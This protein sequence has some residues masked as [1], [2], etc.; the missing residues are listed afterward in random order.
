MSELGKPRKHPPP[1]GPKAA[2]TEVTDNFK[3]SSIDKTSPAHVDPNHT[4]WENIK[5]MKNPYDTSACC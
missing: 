3:R 2:K 1:P 4:H 5:T